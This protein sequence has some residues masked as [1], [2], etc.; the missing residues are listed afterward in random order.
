MIMN[1]CVEVSWKF[2]LV[3]FSVIFI[4]Y[5]RMI[6][7]W[8]WLNGGC[9]ERRSVVELSGTLCRL[10][11]GWEGAECGICTHNNED[12]GPFQ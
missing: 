1:V 8:Y 6:P 9:H 10:V 2:L 7:F 4:L 11:G 12:F 5:S 3:S